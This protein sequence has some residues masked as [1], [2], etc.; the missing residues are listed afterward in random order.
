MLQQRRRRKNEAACLLTA[1]LV[2]GYSR[3][4]SYMPMQSI[5]AVRNV[6]QIIDVRLTTLIL[7][8]NL[9][10]ISHFSIK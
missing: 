10:I 1:M 3:S 6:E 9:A 7:T 5:T 4:I 2:D 8:I